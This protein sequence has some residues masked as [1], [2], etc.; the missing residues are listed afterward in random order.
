MK[1]IIISSHD[2][3]RIRER[4]KEAE[5]KNVYTMRDLKKL[6]DE[7]DHARVLEPHRVPRGVI[8]MNSLIKVRYLTTGKVYTIWLVYPEEANAKR[9][10]VSVFA[11]IGAAL[12]GH[13]KGDTI[14]WS[15]PGGR[16]RIKVEDVV[17]QPETAGDFHL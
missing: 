1:K 14:H 3:I 6:R 2:L 17:Y 8:T 10:R 13:R 16:I 15:A 4:M 12:L 9:S 11:P 7:L 5:L